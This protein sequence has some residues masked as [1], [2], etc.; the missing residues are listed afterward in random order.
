MAVVK[1]PAR[2]LAADGSLIG[3]GRAYVHLPRD[4]A[5]AQPVTGTLSLD[6]WDDAARAPAVVALSDGPSLS[7]Q[8]ES[9]KLSGCV[10]GR[11]LR[12]SC[13]WPG[14]DPAG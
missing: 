9:D 3:E 14:A 5:V 2:L 4:A 8:V 7:I 13:V 1:S 11:I 6:W 12:Y 10:V